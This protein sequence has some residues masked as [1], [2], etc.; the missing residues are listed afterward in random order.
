MPQPDDLKQKIQELEE[1]ARILLIENDQ[2]A[3]RAEDTML[4]GLIAEQISRAEDIGQVLEAGLERISILKDIPFCACCSLT[5]NKAV[6]FKSYLSFTDEDMSSRTI[7]LPE[8]MMQKLAAGDCLLSSDECRQAGMSVELK[9]GSF[10]PLSLICSPFSSRFIEANLFFFADDRSE[11]RLSDVADMLR[12][13]TEMM[14]A[15][16]DNISLFHALQDLNRELDRKVEERTRE[17]QK[18]EERLRLVIEQSPVG[19]VFSRDGIT[20]DANKVYL[21]MF[22]YANIA[23]LRG[24]P[25]IN[26]IAPQCRPESVDR[27]R[28][29]A[30][31]QTLE[32]T[33]ETIGLR[34]DGSHF[35]FHASVNM[36]VLPDGPLTI[37]FL[38]DITERKQMEVQERIAHD[39]L[40]LL[41][42]PEGVLGAIGNILLLVKKSM[43]FEAV[44]IRLQEGDDF[45][46]YENNGFPEEFVR[47]E[48]RLCV[49]DEE[50]K[51][52]HDEQGKPVLECMCGNII[53]GRTDET[54][55]F[56]TGKGS[57][58]TNSTTALLTSMT[59][60]DRQVRIRRCNDDG[61]ESV[62]LIPLRAGDEI[63]GLLQINDR[64][65]DRFTSEVIRF[66][67][68]LGASIGIALSRK[69]SEEAIRESERKYRE[70]FESIVDV[71]YQTDNEG[72]LLVV[73]PS[74]EKLLGYVPDEIVG[75]KLSEFF[76]DPEEQDQFLPLLREKG[77][78]QDYEA[79]L[80]AKDGSVVFVSTN[81]QFFRDKHG[82]IAGVQGITRDVT[83]RKQAEE[84]VQHTLDSLRKAVAATIQVT[85]AVVE[86]RDPYTAGHQT[87]VSDL[88]RAIAREM[89]L[90]QDKIDAVRMAGAIHDVGKVAVPAE[91]LSRP[92]EL[93]KLEFSLIKEH[94]QSGYEILKAVE[95]PWPLAEIVYQHHERMDG[96]GYPRNLKGEDI[97]MEARIIA[98]ADVVE[99]MASHRPYRP[100]LGINLALEEIEKN[101]GILYDAG[102]VDVCLR[103]F[104]EKGY[105]LFQQ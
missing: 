6:I 105:E 86:R 36:I 54:R 4:L 81:A 30:Q 67:E 55:P 43:G 18:D 60:D 48:R 34:K 103:L 29:R 73:S 9:T 93:S 95:S 61:Y 70:L 72:S 79:P 46:Y 98:V 10:T 17:L 35:P 45:P 37:S 91:I 88:A 26:Q 33:Y 68:G 90:P 44:G 84:K 14:A 77:E 63:I 28:R 41:N 42:R 101:K 64:R 82:N 51:I 53:R 85:V 23:E 78:V 47:A 19:I 59:E 94:S 62:A 99:S 100:A 50:G 52:M 58:W 65:R 31:G 3:E 8:T 39:V 1:K 40:N 104:R 89:E 25:R 87:R 92:T 80:R 32:N 49:Y 102:A 75:E 71:F 96:S 76:V 5:G 24:T 38:I 13:V 7:V 66:F 21:S 15:R 12:R 2:L 83:K 57:F 22:G 20:L 56:F 16:M 97:L 74:V 27:I 11:N 69:R